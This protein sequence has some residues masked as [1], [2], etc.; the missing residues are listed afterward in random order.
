MDSPELA[1]LGVRVLRGSF[2]S[3]ELKGLGL[4]FSWQKLN[5]RVSGVVQEC[6]I[7]IC[8]TPSTCCSFGL[9]YA[10]NFGEPAPGARRSIQLLWEGRAMQG[11]LRDV[12]PLFALGL[13]CT[14]LE[15][16][17]WLLSSCQA[18][19]AVVHSGLV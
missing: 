12:L 15:E 7:W 8:T 3:A 14:W 13:V 6:T 5:Q 9:C 17:S 1:M 11:F 16:V 4:G 2:L 18:V 19:Q 10:C